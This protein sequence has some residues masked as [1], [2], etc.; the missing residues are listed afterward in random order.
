[1]NE[2]FTLKNY[3][4]Y[5]YFFVGSFFVYRFLFISM[6]EDPKKFVT[7]FMAAM[8][9]KIFISLMIL[10]VYMWFNQSEGKVFAVNFLVLYLL[11]SGLIFNRLYKVK[12]T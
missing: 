12:K 6:N 5:L 11:Y 9:L 2:A 3:L 7:R 4:S 1:M 10:V 8:G